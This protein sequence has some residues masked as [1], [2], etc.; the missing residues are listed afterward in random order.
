[1]PGSQLF[2]FSLLGWPPAQPCT[3]CLHNHRTELWDDVSPIAF[4]HSLVAVE[5][6]AVAVNRNLIHDCWLCMQRIERGPSNRR[7][8][9]ALFSSCS[10]FREQEVAFL[11]WSDVNL[12]LRRFWPKN[13][14][15][16]QLIPL[17]MAPL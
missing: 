14:S 15:S 6:G 9:I 8:P 5:V 16:S 17:A 1:M 3:S 11:F 7:S 2:S 4:C 13:R 12:K 10:G